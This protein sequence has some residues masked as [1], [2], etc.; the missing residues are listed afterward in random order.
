MREGRIAPTATK[1]RDGRVLIVGGVPNR[2]DMVGPTLASAE[3]YDPRTGTF[4]STGSLHQPRG[5]HTASL[6][7]DGSVIVTGGITALHA[8]GSVDELADAERY[9]PATG[10]WTS[11]G[12][13]LPAPRAHHTAD[14]LDD[15]R[16][17]L[18]GGIDFG[19]GQPA[20]IVSPSS[21]QTTGATTLF[22][23]SLPGAAVVDEG[24]VWRV[25]STLTIDNQS[26]DVAVAVIDRATGAV[27]PQTLSHRRLQAHA[28]SDVVVDGTS[29]A[30]IYGVDGD[31]AV[32]AHPYG[33]PVALVV[34]AGT[35]RATAHPP[36]SWRDDATATTLRDGRVL[37]AGGV[38]EWR[39][40]VAGELFDPTTETFVATCPMVHTRA[41]AAAVELDDGSVLVVGGVA[42][43]GRARLAERFVPGRR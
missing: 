2:F 1:L 27:Q 38:G 17:L 35:E 39:Y 24:R 18:L 9:D 28:M 15:G 33:R 3:L 14:L 7:P 22:T 13:V 31:D 16:V 32:P 25:G 4:S 34:D 30:L 10:R 12:D 23:P 41:G 5:Y 20:D 37:F 26:S 11:L 29:K 42:D 8:D 6:L 43:Y 36:L 19:R 21:G 40:P